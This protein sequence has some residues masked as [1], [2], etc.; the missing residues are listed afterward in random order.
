MHCQVRELV[1]AYDSFRPF[2]LSAIVLS[3]L[4]AA[5]A[6]C[7]SPEDGRLRASGHGGDGG[8]YS[9]KPVHVPSKLD[10]TKSVN[11]AFSSR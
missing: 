6:G 9:N 4:A 7:H 5:L 2:W 3:G 11:D 10:G 8:N 1:C